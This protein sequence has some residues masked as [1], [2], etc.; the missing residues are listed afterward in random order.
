MSQ[1]EALLNQMASTYTS[2]PETEP[3]IVIGEDRFITVP[4]ELERIAVQFDH[5]IETV[6]FDCPRFWDGRDM[7][8]MKI[9][10]NYRRP[11]GALGSYV[12][13]NV[14]VDGDDENVMHFDWTVTKNVTLVKGDLA[15]LVCIKNIDDEGTEQNHWNSEL[16]NDMYVSEGLEG[17]EVIV[18]LNHD[19][20]T[21][22]LMITDKIL[23][24][25]LAATI[26]AVKNGDILTVTI[27]G[28]DGAET[29]EIY[30]GKN[31][32]YV[33][34]GEMPEGYDIQ[35]D[36]DGEPHAIE[37][38]EN[39]ATK[40]EGDAKRSEDAAATAERAAQRSEG[41]ADNAATASGVAAVLASDAISAAD[42]ASKF[43]LS[44]AASEN[45][46]KSNATN[47]KDAADSADEAANRAEEALAAME[48][49]LEGGYYAPSYN[50]DTGAL[51]WT[52]SK[53]NMEVV[54]PVNIRGPKGD[55]GDKGDTGST[56]PK[57]DKGDKG[58][59]G[60]APVRGTD[61]WTEADQNAIIDAV[62]NALPVAEE[63][64]Y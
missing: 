55:K 20:L 32:V 51:S 42:R 10:I 60:P 36:P 21:Q 48:K 29:F 23:S 49:G 18:E 30:D 40:A 63:A 62:L 11:D 1:A 8:K 44:A 3:H 57:G 45:S 58:D 33:G 5:N 15:F 43:A 41:A 38:A 47:A 28:I 26:D 25:G 17:A 27:T 50:A 46:A 6:T 54:A 2:R 12:A 16:C 61:Y 53:A 31:T 35:I 7:S 39:A 34:S 24:T 52:P 14:V 19:V 4:K 22:I 56:G 13:E 37:R 64:S 9:Y 59:A